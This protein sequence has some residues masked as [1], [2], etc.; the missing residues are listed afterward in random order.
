MY[1]STK[2]IMLFAVKNNGAAMEMFKRAS[3]PFVRGAV[4]RCV[5]AFDSVYVCVCVC[6]GAHVHFS[7]QLALSSLLPD[8]P[9]V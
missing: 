3:V 5:V 2:V 1:L 9:S 6:V 8:T 7:R 4:R